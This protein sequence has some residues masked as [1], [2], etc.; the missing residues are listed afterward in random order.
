M[1]FWTTIKSALQSLWANKLRSA[2]AMLGIIIG[3]SA[4]IAMIAMGSGAQAQIT[5]RFQAM[6][7]NLLFV[8][9]AQR[10][11]S[12]ANTGNYQNLV[13]ADGMAIAQ[14]PGV[15]AASPV[16]SGAVQ[17]KY[18]NRNNRTT[19]NGVSMPY[20]AMR[21]F[22]LDKGRFFTES[23]AEG[24]ARVAVIGPNVANTLFAGEDPIG[25]IIKFNNLS[26]KVIGLLQSKGDQGWSNPDDQALVPYTTAMKV[27]FGQTYL[28]EIDITVADEN[29]MSEVSGE[30]PNTS[31]QPWWKARGGTVHQTPPPINSV[32]ALLRRRHRLY[33]LS[34]PDDFMIQNQA[35]LLAS[36]SAS[37]LVFRIL[38]GSI[39]AISLLV[40]GIGIMNIML[41]TVTERTREIGTRKAIG[42]KQRDI[43]L[44][45]LI[46]SMLMSGLGGALGALAGI[47]L[48]KA[49]PLIPAFSSFIT[50]VQP[51]IVI[52]SITVAAIIGMFFGV[53]PAWKASRLDPIEALRYE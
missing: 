9:P 20:F 10:G 49:I 8:R 47:G 50:I 3:V 13:V 19:V 23:E 42:A 31:G 21:N 39:A 35:E 1:L 43:L 17:A 16:V 29:Q 12:G 25:K 22:E 30:P 48:A 15:E 4:V 51:F 18:E 14:L 52:L 37:L 46:E 27:M 41:V 7:T 32:A 34:Q 2:L 33:D 5:A 38:L 24:L 36:F 44:Q 26:F 45:F 6:G 40:G 53:Y 11:T 28:R